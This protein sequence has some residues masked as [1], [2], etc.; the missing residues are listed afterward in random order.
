MAIG[1]SNLGNYGRMGNQM[2]QYAALRGIANQN[3]FDWVV[4]AQ[5][6]FKDTYHS[7]SNIFDCFELLQARER[8]KDVEFEY[9]IQEPPNNIF[10]SDLF[11]SCPDN[12]DLIGYFHSKRYFSSIRKIIFNE[13]KFLNDNKPIDIDKYISIHVRRDDYIGFEGVCPQQ[14]DE[15]YISALL[16]FDKKLP[17][18]VSSDDIEWCSEQDVFSSDRFIMSGLDP[19]KDMFIMSQANGN[20]ISNSTYAW[21]G[22]YLSKNK[23]VVMPKN[24]YGPMASTHSNKEYLVSGWIEV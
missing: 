6:K 22:A 17:V 1:F 12:S 23:N 16:N 21:W 8:M 19:Y 10:C 9:L 11:Y 13:F 5:E 20:I 7:V 24:W 4:P 2:F 14:P 18:I 3:N 15:Y